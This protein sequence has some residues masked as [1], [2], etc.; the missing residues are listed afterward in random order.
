MD[1]VLPVP[2]LLN[3]K[4]TKLTD[5]KDLSLKT[6]SKKYD[7]NFVLKATEENIELA[8]RCLKCLGAH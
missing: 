7:G 4:L 8:F 2:R 6:Q 5:G 3:D 1:V